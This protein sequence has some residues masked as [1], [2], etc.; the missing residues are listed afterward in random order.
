MNLY[1]KFLWSRMDEVLGMLNN[2]SAYCYLRSSE[3]AEWYDSTNH[4]F[5]FK[6]K[7]V[8]QFWTDIRLN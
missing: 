2:E 4:S 5:K 7:K 1:Y 8:T 6:V 3:D